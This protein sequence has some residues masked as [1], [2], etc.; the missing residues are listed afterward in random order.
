[1]RDPPARYPI[2]ETKHSWTLKYFQE[3]FYFSGVDVD[4]IIRIIMRP[5]M[6]ITGD[7]IDMVITKSNNVPDI[8]ESY[9]VDILSFM[10]LF[11]LSSDEIKTPAPGSSLKY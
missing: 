2:L 4:C 9:L 3:M 11:Y 1:M 8:T 5:I 6:I 7:D 10:H